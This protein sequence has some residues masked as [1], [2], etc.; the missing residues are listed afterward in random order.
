MTIPVE[1][2]Y[3]SVTITLAS[4]LRTASGRRVL[5]NSKRLLATSGSDV[6]VAAIATT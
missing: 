4:E 2:V 3:S 1:F 5:V 6:V